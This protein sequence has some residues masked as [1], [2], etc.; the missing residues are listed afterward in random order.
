MIIPVNVYNANTLSMMIGV[1]A[2]PSV[3][4]GGTNAGLGWRPQVMLNTFTLNPSAAASPGVLAIGANTLALTPQGSPVPN[5][6]Q[7]SLPGSI[8]WSSVQLYIYFA[9]TDTASWI[10][11]NQGQYVTGGLFPP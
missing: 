11:L 3:W 1:N 4:I 5:Q 6:T 9:T 2:P 10:I 8:Q 7:L